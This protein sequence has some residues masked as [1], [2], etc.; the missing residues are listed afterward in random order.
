MI[1][2]VDIIRGSPN[3][4][5]KPEYALFIKDDN[6]EEV[7][8]VSKNKLIR[9]IKSYKPK[10]VAVDNI[11]ELFANKKELISFLKSIPS[12]TKLVQIAYRDTLPNL[13]KRFGI[14]INAR[15]PFDEAKALAYLVNFGIGEV[16]SAFKDE[17]VITISRNRSLGKG[18]WRQKK[19]RRRVHDSVRYYFREI[20]KMIKDLGFE[21]KEEVKLGFGGISKGKLVI[22]AGRED[23]PI[24][25]FKTRD[26]QVRVEAVEKDK[27]EFIPLANV[28][29]YT[30]VGVDPGTTTAIAILDLNGNVLGFYSKKELSFA[31][32]VELILNYG[33]PVLIATDK[34]NPPDF[35]LKLKKAFQASLYSPKEDMSIEKKRS[36][37]SE[38]RFSNDHERDALASAIEAYKQFKNKLMNVEKRIPFGYDVE[39]IKAGI[40]KGVSLQTL[41][42]DEKEELKEVE[43]RTEERDFTQELKKK[44]EKIKELEYE[45]E[46]LRKEI[47][48]LKSEIE[49]MRIKILR[50]SREEHERIRKDN[51]I[52][53]LQGEIRELRKI[54]RIKDEEIKKLEEKVEKLKRMKYLELKGWK[55][56][57]FIQKFTR[58]EIERVDREYGILEGDVVYIKDS[59]GGGK[60]S[61]KLL[62]EKGVKAVITSD[63]SH[64]AKEEFRKYKVPVIE[65]KDINVLVFEEIAMVSSEELKEKIKIAEEEIKRAEIENI[66]KIIEE[67]RKERKLKLY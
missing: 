34:K 17:T 19:Y 31:K 62:C 64:L 7:K 2:G 10:Y 23:I 16:I 46:M 36:L 54:I 40:L 30:I 42:S 33:Q 20:K 24:N 44:D 57:K 53:N 67:Y 65:S 43:K 47:D 66:E 9:L 52:R 1:F 18:G 25:S 61:A 15:N 51:F 41:L 39:R 59:S 13:A 56:L 28:K 60:A 5:R 14:E 29:N 35:V 48:K 27:I 55:T 3:S 38:Y 26:V 49:R 11:T 12:K 50:I 21:F 32:A 22:K 58:D 4:K 63:M 8:K 45:N 37:T 6:F